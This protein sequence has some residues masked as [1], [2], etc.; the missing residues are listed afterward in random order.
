MAILTVI[1]ITFC[2]MIGGQGFKWARRC[3]LP[4]IAVI[5][6]A[7]KEEKKKWKALIYLPLIGILSIGYGESSHL[8][9]FLGGSDF[10][11]RIVYGLLL[12][13]PFI[14]FGKWYACIALPI[15]FSIK[16]GGFKITDKIDFLYEDLIRYLTLGT[17]IVL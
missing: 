6:T 4:I 2:G 10:W 12:S 8:R 16:A 7:M 9:K 14:F 11:T 1:L 17:L 3:I 5:Y 15:A 13:I